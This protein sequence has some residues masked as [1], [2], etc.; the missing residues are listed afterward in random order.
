[1]MVT[2]ALTTTR[3]GAVGRFAS[4]CPTG[5]APRPQ[6]LAMAGAILPT[7]FD[8]TEVCVYLVAGWARRLD[9]PADGRGRDVFA[10]VRCVTGEGSLTQA[11]RPR[12]A[13]R[14][15]GN[16]KALFAQATLYSSSRILP[17]AVAK[18]PSR[19][20]QSRW[21]VFCGRVCRLCTRKVRA[22]G[23]R[24]VA[25]VRTGIDWGGTFTDSLGIPDQ[26]DVRCRK[27]RKTQY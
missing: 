26:G 18:S 12:R 14:S 6:L 8:V 22:G 1:M 27:Q 5:R 17:Q 20:W 4:A 25:S 2:P 21:A 16:M 19:P 7:T 9:V 11:A 23:E 10:R 15:V 24:L 3:K 13:R